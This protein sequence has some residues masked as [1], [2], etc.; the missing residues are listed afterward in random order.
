MLGLG[1]VG[2]LRWIFERSLGRR[3][4]KI[5]LL[6]ILHFLKGFDSSR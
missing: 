1:R 2:M 3:E 4:V 6:L 5:K